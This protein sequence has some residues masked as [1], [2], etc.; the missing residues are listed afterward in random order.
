M[1]EYTIILLRPDDLT[2][3]YGQDIYVAYVTA[4]DTRAAILAAQNEVYLADKIDGQPV[5][6]KDDYALLVFF[7][8]HHYCLFG[9]QV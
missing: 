1:N 6:S 5:A 7:L 4:K 2:D 3:D 8:G 9:G